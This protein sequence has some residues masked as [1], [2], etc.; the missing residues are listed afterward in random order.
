MPQP[1]PQKAQSKALA[2]QLNLWLYRF[3]Q[4]WT[5]V[6]L[7]LLGIFVSLPF[8]A[9]TFMH[10]GWERAANVVYIAYKPFCHQFGFRSMHLYGEQLFYPRANTGSTL[11]SYEEMIARTQPPAFAEVDNL[12]A[13]SADDMLAWANLQWAARAFVGNPEMGYK[14]TVCA[15]DMS[16]Y[17][18]L[19]FGGLIYAIFPRRIRPVPLWLWFWLGI[20]PIGIDGFSQ[21]LSYPPFE[22]WAVRETLPLYRVLTGAAFGLMN[23]WLGFPYLA[24]S[25]D[26]TREELEEK[27]KRSGITLKER[28]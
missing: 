15:R 7:A 25:F 3:T 17:L 1:T 26:I 21:L 8:V 16:I 14:V 4:H 12:Y 13:E 11:T 23:A 28:A 24:E 20:G 9:P 2:L 6:I 18:G 27:F 5:V 10:L 22:L 19:W